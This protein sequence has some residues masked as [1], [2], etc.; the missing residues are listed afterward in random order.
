MQ[1]LAGQ[2]QCNMYWRDTTV[3][4]KFATLAHVSAVTFDTLKF[5][6]TLQ[7]SGVSVPQAEA[8]AA[9]VRDSNE[10]AELATKSDV[11]EL[12]NELRAEMR[13]M[14]LRLTIKLGAM[15]VVAVGVI[16]TI[17]KL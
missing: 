13:E 3:R 14:E 4:A 12:R 6:K 17:I 1:L 7:A 2:H 15:L 5:V 11:R 9:A 16:A 8:I 10:A